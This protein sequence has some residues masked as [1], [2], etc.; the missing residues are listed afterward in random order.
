MAPA[1]MIQKIKTDALV[2][3]KEQLRKISEIEDTTKLARE[4]TLVDAEAYKQLKEAE[5]NQASDNSVSSH[6][7]FRCFFFF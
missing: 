5:A 3:E 6:L 4:K 1:A 2:Q 7:E